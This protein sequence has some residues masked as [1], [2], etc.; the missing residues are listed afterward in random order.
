[1][2]YTQLFQACKMLTHGMPD[3]VKQSVTCHVSRLY[4]SSGSH[5]EVI[6]NDVA[7]LKHESKLPLVSV[8]KGLHQQVW[9]S[10]QLR[11]MQPG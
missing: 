4:L 10:L 5:S 3:K 8:L 1:M 7:L 2:H 6:Y 11:C 9:Q